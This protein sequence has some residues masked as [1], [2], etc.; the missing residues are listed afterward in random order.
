MGIK[1]WFLNGLGYLR[2]AKVGEEIE[3]PERDFYGV[4]VFHK[5]GLIPQFIDFE[6]GTHLIGDSS[7]EERMQ[8]LEEAFAQCNAKENID[9]ERTISLYQPY[10][11]GTSELVEINARFRHGEIKGIWP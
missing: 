3:E 9:R 1:S 10:I 6:E 5:V 11:D 7:V 4:I 8:V 2:S